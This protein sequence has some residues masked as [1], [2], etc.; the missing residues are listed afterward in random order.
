MSIPPPPL[1]DYVRLAAALGP[2]AAN[3]LCVTKWKDGIDIEVPCGDVDQMF[4]A[5]DQEIVR[6]VLQAA[7]NECRAIELA[8]WREYKIGRKTS[9][10]TEGRSDG[11]GECAAVTKALEFH[12]E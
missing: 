11:A 1:P 9:A 6:C 12:H 7:A 5:R 8:A 3:Q 4:R 2:I 10:H